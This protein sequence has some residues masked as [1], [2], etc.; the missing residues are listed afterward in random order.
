MCVYIYMLISYQLKISS[1]Y[2]IIITAN[3]LSLFKL[4]I[5]WL[6]IIL[7][8]VPFFI[9]I[10]FYM[11]T[12][13]LFLSYFPLYHRIQFL[14]NYTFCS[15]QRSFESSLATFNYFFFSFFFV[16]YFSLL[17]I[18][19]IFCI[20][21]RLEQVIMH[22]AVLRVSKFFK[23]HALDRNGTNA[24]VIEI[25]YFLYVYNIYIYIYLY[26]YNIYIIHIVLLHSS[27]VH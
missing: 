8:F 10:T 9:C 26:V 2:R 17:H 14:F 7:Q 27:Y 1:T 23:V 16:F 4:S 6:F 25:N 21:A 19:T 20:F 18:L 3:F 12:I 22:I 15:S 13:F 11:D 24:V 5:G